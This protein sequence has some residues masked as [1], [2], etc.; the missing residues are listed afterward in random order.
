ME[1]KKKKFDPLAKDWLM[2]DVGKKSDQSQ[3]VLLLNNKIE[4]LDLGLNN[5]L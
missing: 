4:K 2:G 5:I 1:D 3:E